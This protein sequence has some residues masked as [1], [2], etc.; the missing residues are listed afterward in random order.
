MAAVLYLHA[1]DLALGGIAAMTRDLHSSWGCYEMHPDADV[2]LGAASHRIHGF[3]RKILG[4]PFRK[5]LSPS[6]GEA[7]EFDGTTCSTIS[8][9]YTFM[10][11][12]NFKSPVMECLRKA[13]A[14]FRS[15]EVPRG[16][17]RS[18]ISRREAFE[19]QIASASTR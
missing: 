9:M 1:G 8:L 3:V 18:K 16:F 5:G 13:Q 17:A 4:V 14:S 15:A 19:G 6:V 2:N 10:R 12:D 7:S 11:I